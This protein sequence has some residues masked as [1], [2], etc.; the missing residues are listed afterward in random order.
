MA[1]I[2]QRKTRRVEAFV[3]VRSMPPAGT[4]KFNRGEFGTGAPHA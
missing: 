4:E 2:A 1:M 3:K